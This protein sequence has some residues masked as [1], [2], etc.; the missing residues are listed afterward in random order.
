MRAIFRLALDDYN[1]EI[2]NLALDC[3]AP[4]GSRILIRRLRSRLLKKFL[5]G[6]FKY[7]IP[8]VIIAWLLSSVDRSQLVRLSRHRDH[9]PMLIGGGLLTFVA[10]C[11]SFYRWYLLVRALDLPFRLADAFRL[12]SLGYLL[13]FVSGGSIGGDLFKA[14]FIAHEQ[15]GRRTEAVATVLIDRVVGMVSLLI[16]TSAAILF[17]RPH[18]ASPLVAAICNATL[19]ATGIALAGILLILIPPHTSHLLLVV[20]RRTP[21]IGITLV[22]L[23]SALQVYRRRPRALLTVLAL[24]ISVHTLLTFALYLAAVAIL[25]DAPSLGSHFII[26]PLSM[27]AGALPFT[28]A[29]LGTFE[30]AMDQLYLL[31]P[32]PPCSDGILVAMA[33]RLMTIVIAMVGVGYYWTSRREVRQLLE[34]AEH[35]HFTDEE[36][37]D[38]VAQPDFGDQVADKKTPASETS[39][40]SRGM[41]EQVD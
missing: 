33:Y 7:A 4:T 30:V 6:F 10:I 23:I 32:V 13:T 28:P 18:S 16:M 19:I 29:G 38:V 11:L 35:Q 1:C 15:P 34:E 21:K 37:Q 25:P 31:V 17:T 12:G 40:N 2:N 22:R 39:L 14:V 36:I 20:A 5:I 24:G 3:Q 26:V 9:W 41:I 27:V 8:L